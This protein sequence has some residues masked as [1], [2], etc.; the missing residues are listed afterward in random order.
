MDPEKNAR[1]NRVRTLLAAGAPSFR[2]LA[3]L[4]SL[5]VLAQ[6]RALAPLSE[7]VPVFTRCAHPSA[8]NNRIN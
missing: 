4:P 2:V 8:K 7:G 5:Q 6:H 3:T 1:R